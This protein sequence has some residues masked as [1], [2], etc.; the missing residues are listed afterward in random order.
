MLDH[1]LQSDMLTLMSKA[2]MDVQEEFAK[3]ATPL[4]KLNRF[5]DVGSLI[6]LSIRL[7][8]LNAKL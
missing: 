8:D 1:Y 6:E 7:G 5:L 2:F 4:E 3:A